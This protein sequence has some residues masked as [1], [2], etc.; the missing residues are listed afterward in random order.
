MASS[1]QEAR[2]PRNGLKLASTYACVSPDPVSARLR[3]S[4]PTLGVRGA[5][6][7]VRS[8]RS[9]VSVRLPL[10]CEVT[11]GVRGARL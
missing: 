5:V 11:V 3:S 9:L 10:V 6:L 7:G 2:Q 1:R 8:G 4:A